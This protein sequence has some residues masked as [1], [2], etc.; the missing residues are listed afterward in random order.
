MWD[1]E[2]ELSGALKSAVDSPAPAPRIQLN[3][4]LR[5]GRRRV[6]AHRLGAA[7]GVVAVVVGVGFGA[8]SLRAT[9]LTSNPPADNPA[10]TATPVA[11]AWSVANFPTLTPYDT[12]QPA[13]GKPIPLCDNVSG[14][15][16]SLTFDFTAVPPARADAFT[17]AVGAVAGPA[18]LSGLNTIDLASGSHRYWI[19]VTDADGADGAG[20]VT[21][22][23]SA[24]TGTPVEAADR[25]PY[26]SGT[27]A[28]PRRLVRPDGTVLQCYPLKPVPAAPP[29]VPFFSMNQA[30]RIYAPSGTVTEI[31]LRSYSGADFRVTADGRGVEFVSQGRDALPLTEDQ[32]VRIALAM[33]G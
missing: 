17:A 2:Q 11:A 10:V 14:I 20:S 1:D 19:D 4:V 33:A 28:P 3:D 21:V 26:R 16:D 5:R 13:A 32:L 22:A 23:I 25:M 9:P 12:W 7:A 6:F 24:F 30:L 29:E 15:Q 31:V 27:C 8:M 18:K